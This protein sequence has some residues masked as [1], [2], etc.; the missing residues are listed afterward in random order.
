MS[1]RAKKRPQMP[2]GDP[3]ICPIVRQK[4]SSDFQG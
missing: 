3:K 4:N 2:K 1:T